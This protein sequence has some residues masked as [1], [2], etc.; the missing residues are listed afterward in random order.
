M[1]YRLRGIV[2]IFPVFKNTK[3][4]LT[5]SEDEAKSIDQFTDAKFLMY[6]S[7]TKKDA[8]LQATNFGVLHFSTHADAGSFTV[9]ANIEFADGNLFLNELYTKQLDNNLVVLSACETGI[10]KLS[11]GEGSMSLARGFQYAGINQLV[12]SLWKVNDKSTSQIMHNFYKNYSKFESV[13]IANQKSK[14]QYLDDKSITNAKKSPYYWSAF[15][16]YGTST[17]KA[18]PTILNYLLFTF[19]GLAIALLLWTVIRKLKH[20][21]QA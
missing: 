2:R 21:R 14:Q 6:T 18:K 17:A 8:F 12:F 3:K 10:G 4:A 19:I 9:P 20:G 5:F 7:A 11:K 15:V 1:F 16:Y 13:A